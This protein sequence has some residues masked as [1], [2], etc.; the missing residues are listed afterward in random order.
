M[1][2]RERTAWITVITIVIFFGA[3]YGATLSGFVPAGSMSAFHLGLLS[4]IGLAVFQVGLNLT[5]TILNPKEARTPRDERERMIH[6][7]SHVIGYYVMMIGTAV[8]LVVTHLPVE[9]DHFFDVIVRTVNIGVLA[10]VIA[11]LSVAIAQ[12]VMYRRGH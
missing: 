9:G 4:I 6:A 12:I 11:A 1:S 2:F 8:T 3:Y 5:A 10:M 7:R